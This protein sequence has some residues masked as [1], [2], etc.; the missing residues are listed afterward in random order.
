MQII[1]NP[2]EKYLIDA[3]GN[4]VCLQAD[5]DLMNGMAEIIYQDALAI[6]KEMNT[7]VLVLFNFNFH[8]LFYTTEHL[9]NGC[10]EI[11]S[12]KQQGITLWREYLPELELG[13]IQDGTYSK[14]QIIKRDVSQD[15]RHGLGVRLMKKLR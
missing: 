2:T 7:E 6:G 4:V 14:I 1:N 13:V 8:E 9:R 15:I 5:L 11:L 10:S 3:N 12:R